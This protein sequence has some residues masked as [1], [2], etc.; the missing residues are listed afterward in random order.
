MVIVSLGIWDT[1]THRYL[2]PMHVL[3]ITYIETLYGQVVLY[4]HALF[5]RVF[6]LAL[7][8][9]SRSKSISVIVCFVYN[10]MLRNKCTFITN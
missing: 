8:N 1:K 10:V 6:K 5:K 3:T 7:A 2:M 4:M 9:A